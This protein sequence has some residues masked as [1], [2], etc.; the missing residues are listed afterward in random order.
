MAKKETNEFYLKIK[1]LAAERKI[2]L[3]Q[4]ERNL[5]F[6]SGIISNWRHSSPTADKLDKVAT[7]FHVSTDY[8][9]DRKNVLT[10]AEEQIIQKFREESEKMSQKDK[11]VFA[12]K[13]I[14]MI[15]LVH[16]LGLD[17]VQN[18]EV[19]YEYEDDK[20]DNKKK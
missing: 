6:S 11:A 4:L 16:V 19:S 1:E 13:V 18:I 2:S 7:Y 20:S 5:G 15:P 3:A 8:L 17:N 14:Q 10:R 9:L 12:N